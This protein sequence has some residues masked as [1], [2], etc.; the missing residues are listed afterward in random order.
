MS[1]PGELYDRDFLLWTKDQAA[2]L[3]RA[4]NS[5][6]PLDW[7]NLAEEIESLG[8][9]ERRELGSQIRRILLHLFK[10]AVSPAEGPRRGWRATVRTARADIS[11]VLRD[12][13]SLRREIE[14]VISEEAE[15]AAELAAADLDAHAEL[16]DAAE[17]QLAA[18]S[19]TTTEVVG[20]W[21]PERPQAIGV[22]TEPSAC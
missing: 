22:S 14:Q 13:P 2:S 4:R 3:R 20:D 5:N 6:L 10:L 8:K 11:K 18:T 21:F 7:E 1:K 16:N 19:F 9:S 12:S 15:L 17:A